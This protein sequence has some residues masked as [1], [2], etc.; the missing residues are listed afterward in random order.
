MTG[1][2]PG[3]LGLGVA[4]G[5]PLTQLLTATTTITLKDEEMFNAFI[6]G[7]KNV[8]SIFNNVDYAANVSGGRIFPGERLYRFEEGSGTSATRLKGTYKTDGYSVTITWK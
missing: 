4:V 7:L 6:E 3:Q 5:S 2:V 1:F 8:K